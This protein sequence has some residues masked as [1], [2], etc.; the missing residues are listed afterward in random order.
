[1]SLK[2][3]ELK[4]NSNARGRMG[5]AIAQALAKDEHRASENTFKT[6]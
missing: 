5:G 6:Y 4:V 2:L 1:M 3:I